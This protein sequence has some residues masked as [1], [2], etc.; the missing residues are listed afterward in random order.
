MHQT[1][2][3]RAYY[4]IF[5]VANTPDLGYR[6]CQNDAAVIE[7]SLKFRCGLCAMS[8]CQVRLSP[9]IR[10]IEASEFGKECRARH[11]EIVWNRSLQSLDGVRRRT[12]SQCEEGVQSGKIL[13][14]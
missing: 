7:H 3:R 14:L 11:R 2:I 12:M 9:D 5:R 4:R 6:V 13:E 8:C 1:R 10:G